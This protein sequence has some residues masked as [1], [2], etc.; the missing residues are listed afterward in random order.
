MNILLAARNGS[1]IAIEAATAA[2][3]IAAVQALIAVGAVRASDV[4][5]Q[6]DDIQIMNVLL[7]QPNM[8]N[9]HIVGS[10]KVDAANAVQVA[11]VIQ[12]A[13]VQG[14]SIEGLTLDL[15]GVAVP[16]ERA[17]ILQQLAAI[18]KNFS[19][20][21]IKLTPGN[22][23][24]LTAAAA[25][26]TVRVEVVMLPDGTSATQFTMVNPSSP[27]ATPLVTVTV[28]VD[29]G[30]IEVVSPEG[31]PGSIQMTVPASKTVTVTLNGIVTTIVADEAIGLT[32]AGRMIELIGV[33]E[34]KSSTVRITPTAMPAN[35]HS[36]LVR[37]NDHLFLDHAGTAMIAE[38]IA[39]IGAPGA[40]LEQNV[41][42]FNEVQKRID[43][44]RATNPN[45]AL[46]QALAD[47][48]TK[49]LREV[50]VA[51]IPTVS[52]VDDLLT[53][54][55]ATA[56]NQGVVQVFRFRAEEGDIPADFFQRLGQLNVEV[57][58]VPDGNDLLFVTSGHH[59]RVV[60]GDA[61]RAFIVD[62]GEISLLGFNIGISGQ[63][64]IIANVGRVILAD[65]P[66]LNKLDP[67]HFNAS[68]RLIFDRAT[69]GTGVF[70]N[71]D[72][73]IFIVAQEF[74]G[75]AKIGLRVYEVTDAAAKELL[76]NALVMTPQQQGII[77]DLVLAALRGTPTVIRNDQI[78][79]LLGLTAQQFA[80]IAPIFTDALGPRTEKGMTV[81]QA[82]AA[83]LNFLIQV[84]ERARV[85]GTAYGVAFNQFRVIQAAIAVVQANPS[86]AV[87]AFGMQADAF[88]QQMLP[89]LMDIYA[90]FM[91]GGQAVEA[92]MVRQ[93]ILQMIREMMKI[94][95]AAANALLA[96]LDGY[97]IAERRKLAKLLGVTGIDVDHASDA[98]LMGVI[99]PELI[100][101]GITQP[102]QIIALMQTPGIEVILGQNVTGPELQSSIAILAQEESAVSERGPPSW[103]FWLKHGFWAPV[104]ETV[105]FHAI[106]RIMPK[107][108]ISAWYGFIHRRSD[109][110]N[111]H[112]AFVFAH[113]I[114]DREDAERLAEQQGIESQDREQFI[115]TYMVR[116]GEARARFSREM[117]DAVTQSISQ[118]GL[119]GFFSGVIQAYRKHR[120]N[121]RKAIAAQYVTAAQKEGWLTFEERNAIIAN[122]NRGKDV[123]G[124]AYTP[125][126]AIEDAQSKMRTRMA[127][128]TAKTAHARVEVLQSR[129]LISQVEVNYLLNRMGRSELDPE[130]V[131]NLAD[132]I[133]SNKQEQAS[134]GFFARTG[135]KIAQIFGYATLAALGVGLMKGVIAGAAVTTIGNLGLALIA[136]PGLIYL[137]RNRVELNAKYPNAFKANIASN[138]LLLAGLALS[139][140][141][142]A[143]WLAP[144][145]FLIGGFVYFLT[146]LFKITEGVTAQELSSFFGAG[147]L[148]ISLMQL[149]VSKTHVG[150]Q[151]DLQSSFVALGIFSFFEL[152]AVLLGKREL[153]EEE[154]P[155]P[156][157]ASVADAPAW[158]LTMVDQN[159]R[160]EGPM[161]QSVFSLGRRE[162]LSE[163]RDRLDKEYPLAKTAY[164]QAITRFAHGQITASQ[165]QKER[166]RYMRIADQYTDVLAIESGGYDF[167]GTRSQEQMEAYALGQHIV[168]LE[169]PD[170]GRRI[171]GIQARH[172]Q[173][174][175][176]RHAIL[177]SIVDLRQRSAVG[178][179]ID[180]VMDADMTIERKLE[181]L[182][183]LAG[184]SHLTGDAFTTMHDAIITAIALQGV[185][186]GI[187]ALAD[188]FAIIVHPDDQRFFIEN[189]RFV[190]DRHVSERAQSPSMFVRGIANSYLWQAINMDLGELRRANEVD[191]GLKALVELE[192]RLQT[193]DETSQD[194]TNPQRQVHQRFVVMM[195]QRYLTGGTPS[196]IM[197][198][199]QPSLREAVQLARDFEVC[200]QFMMNVNV[201]DN[202][203][204]ALMQEMM[205]AM[206]SADPVTALREI[207]LRLG[208]Y[209]AAMA[210]LSDPQRQ[211]VLAS[212]SRAPAAVVADFMTTLSAPHADAYLPVFAQAMIEAQTEGIG[213]IAPMNGDDVREFNAMVLAGEARVADQYVAAQETRNERLLRDAWYRMP[214]VFM[215]AV[216]PAR[217]GEAKLLV[218]KLISQVR[219]GRITY[220]DAIQVLQ[221]FLTAE[222]AKYTAPTPQEIQVQQTSRE[223]DDAQPLAERFKGFFV[224]PAD[225]IVDTIMR[226]YIDTDRSLSRRE[227]R[228]IRKQ[229]E[230]MDHPSLIYMINALMLKE[231]VRGVRVTAK[232]VQDERET[233]IDLPRFSGQLI[234]KSEPLKRYL[235]M[236]ATMAAQGAIGIGQ[237]EEMMAVAQERSFE[238][239]SEAA[240]RSYVW[241][242][243]FASITDLTLEQKNALHDKVK[244]MSHNRLVYL[245]QYIYLSELTKTEELSGENLAVLV[246]AVDN[247]PVA[248]KKL[249]LDSE[250]MKAFQL[251]LAAMRSVASE[252]LAA[253]KRQEVE[254]QR[255]LAG[256]AKVGARFK[257]GIQWTADEMRA[258]LTAQYI[259][260]NPQ[261]SQAERQALEARLNHLDDTALSYLTTTLML[262]NRLGETIT[263]AEF[264]TEV[265]RVE[266][267]VDQSGTLV[268]GTTQH[269]T[270]LNDA[271]IGLATRAKAAAEAMAKAAKTNVFDAYD[272]DN[273]T[274]I[275]A[276]YLEM[277]EKNKSLSKRQRKALTARI[278][279]L[280]YYAIKYLGTKLTLE[281]QRI[282]HA[283][284]FDETVNELTAIEKLTDSEGRI[285]H[286]TPEQIRY[287]RDLVIL[288]RRVHPSGRGTQQAVQPTFVQPDQAREEFML[289]L[290]LALDQT[291][292][293]DFTSQEVGARLEHFATFDAPTQK[294][295]M[296][297][298]V[299]ANAMVRNAATP[300][301]KA[302][303]LYMLRRAL[304]SNSSN[305]HVIAA[306]MGLIEAALRLAHQDE[307]IID[308]ICRQFV[309]FSEAMPHMNQAQIVDQIHVMTEN[310]ENIAR[311]DAHLQPFILAQIMSVLQSSMTAPSAVMPVVTVRHSREA[312]VS[313]ARVKIEA[314]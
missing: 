117:E 178:R 7:A 214:A 278:M 12:A 151:S 287:V 230:A 134:T 28:R 71:K 228:E 138:V 9:I 87:T 247:L 301:A 181:L 48:M 27:A 266:A 182:E 249:K 54:I 18:I 73:R 109:I 210:S 154:Q 69:N 221:T 122:L 149:F 83:Q 65:D 223:N 96:Q 155:M 282:G 190:L 269:Q 70:I 192:T 49:R 143:A 78:M 36:H 168:G 225:Q 259:S 52:R 202:V 55:N 76:R 80:N 273:E 86:I 248:G 222:S 171:A 209:L 297:N 212:L 300:R 312:V 255:R 169:H 220:A 121:N 97:N 15:T 283:T 104:K 23:V 196:T 194:E 30:N 38:S 279:R 254:K 158:M 6:I 167:V 128:P 290:S 148:S 197:N 218:E 156:T 3:R 16:A 179:L 274:S 126:R 40:N 177:T 258:F 46:I 91:A 311:F 263:P 304:N 305:V 102:Q 17:A 13:R 75:G 150:S 115:R 82:N 262:R 216:S 58:I 145:I 185:D 175:I 289:A 144:S 119:L 92:Q 309:E 264:D 239:M 93:F 123:L 47:A 241:D 174:E 291:P 35:E 236:L 253:A 159:I 246:D 120:D 136:I 203:R 135:L 207:F 113:R 146:S 211:A 257:G 226:Q 164:E 295:Y 307:A 44:L 24:Q 31:I 79:A 288:S 208:R 68:L 112:A 88:M 1:V 170:F 303:A 166:T 271:Q 139:L 206:D 298:L 261:L 4:T 302:L 51:S 294:V 162:S 131:M 265:K 147:A 8:Q 285:I 111:A 299:R 256:K 124:V 22:T 184:V 234:L 56:S 293:F 5:L 140:T 306:Q 153:G 118:S 10:I 284:T 245:A 217:R 275:R 45:D 268:S 37:P 229:L 296:E 41:R 25:T 205:N 137:Y 272:P 201:P 237:T 280:D 233:I 63:S 244:K 85:S 314:P 43:A 235:D 176:R 238:S 90:Q 32:M 251:K 199:S 60:A 133:A 20:I 277:I 250:P 129:G 198:L 191:L 21:N 116:K 29:N 132:R 34:M 281:A 172:A 204:Q 42:V 292:G 110:D 152:L 84:A 243:H 106:L 227:R 193:F 11:T 188:R 53:K 160:E 252:R 127:Q 33:E 183:K 94:D 260:S 157:A 107:W 173:F 219:E 101:R 130:D 224:L 99:L 81:I 98:A 200:L 313:A 66:V 74:V 50:F 2:A 95:E 180:T 62:R 26:H 67:N 114:V 103:S 141:P 142:L 161:L 240:L 242:K 187:S 186:R 270:Y 61:L 64:T 195:R 108:A 72:G 231:M 105:I 286:G 215:R 308:A 39:T 276:R 213:N 310:I 163:K 57:L 59:D 14:H 125:Q 232:V 100:G 77:V 189:L 19:G 89:Q 267:L 165:L